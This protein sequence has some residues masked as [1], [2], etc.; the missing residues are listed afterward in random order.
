MLTEPRPRA[1]RVA[2]ALLLALPVLLP[3]GACSSS[4]QSFVVL[5]LEHAP[6]ETSVTAIAGITTVEVEVNVLGG[7]P[8]DAASPPRTLDYD[9]RVLD[10][11]SLTIQNPPA[12][13]TLSV[14]FS[15]GERGSVT[16]TVSLIDA[17]N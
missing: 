15:G 11:G 6:T 16:F 10:G 8:Q 7:N 2:V 4:P 14:G 13:G 3:L 12:L 1:G 17:Q 9:A 5:D